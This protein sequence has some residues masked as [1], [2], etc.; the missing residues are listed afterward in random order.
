MLLFEVNQ[1]L[2]TLGVIESKLKNAFKYWEINSLVKSD[3][4]CGMLGIQAL[5][6]WV[7]T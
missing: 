3:D 1:R 4:Y 7:Q 2:I 6:F 5:C